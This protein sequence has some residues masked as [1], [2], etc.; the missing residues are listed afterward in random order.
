MEKP[1]GE[2][3][4]TSRLPWWTHSPSW[5]IPKRWQARDPRL[6]SD[7]A[8][9]VIEALQTETASFELTIRRYSTQTAGRE[10]L[11]GAWREIERMA[12]QVRT[13]QRQPDGMRTTTATTLK[14]ETNSESPRS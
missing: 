2:G 6:V 10:Q 4:G 7:R 3:S 9:F 12:N 8:M 11:L 14:G 5:L 13:G 1:I